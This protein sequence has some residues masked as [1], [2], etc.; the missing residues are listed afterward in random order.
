[1]LMQRDRNGNGREA[2]QEKRTEEYKLKKKGTAFQR[3]SDPRELKNLKMFVDVA[4][5]LVC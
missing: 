5:T 3:W 1:M 4:V 2:P